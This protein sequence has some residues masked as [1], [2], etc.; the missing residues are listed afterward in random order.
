MS[1]KN[2]NNFN[3][4][5]TESVAELVLGGQNVYMPT[6]AAPDLHISKTQ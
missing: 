1:I 2:R 4:I 5:E 6:E 3:S